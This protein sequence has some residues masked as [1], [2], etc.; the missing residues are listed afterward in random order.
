MKQPS[1]KIG[2]SIQN[3]VGEVADSFHIRIIDYAMK[4]AVL[5]ALNPLIS[6][7]LKIYTLLIFKKLKH[8]ANNFHENG[9]KRVC[10]ESLNRYFTMNCSFLTCFYAYLEY[11]QYSTVLSRSHW[12]FSPSAELST[13]EVF[14]T[15]S[16]FKFRVKDD[17]TSFKIVN[18]F[19]ISIYK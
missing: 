2:I 8:K 9:R 16:Q 12:L 14:V 19:L 1:I 17:Q 15:R 5:S 18:F 6:Q 3:A 13:S 10:S 4:N 11:R 7:Y